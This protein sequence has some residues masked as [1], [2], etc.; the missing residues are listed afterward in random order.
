MHDE[1]PRAQARVGVWRYWGMGRRPFEGDFG[2]VLAAAQH[3]DGS[4]F[5]TLWRWLAP[6]VAAYFRHHGE[7]D[8]DDLTSETFLRVFRDLDRF[9]GDDG[10]FR[11]WVFVVAHHRWIDARRAQ[12]RRPDTSGADAPDDLDAVPA[13][14]DE[15]LR[16]L[17]TAEIRRW[18]GDLVP[19][20][21]DVLLLRLFGDLTIGQ[22]AEAT[23]RSEGATKALQR[24][25]LANLQRRHLAGGGTPQIDGPREIPGTPVPLPA[26]PTVTQVP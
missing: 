5:A 12:G 24:R 14:E 11:S 13:A 7:R 1:L 19:D 26:D 18:V 9:E 21:R 6:S 8:P 23:G 22:I 4:A 20:Q 25:G 16:S 2:A 3:R 15:A 17:S 10:A